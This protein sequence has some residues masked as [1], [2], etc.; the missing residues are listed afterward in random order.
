[1]IE[2]KLQKRFVKQLI[3][4]VMQL[5]L[6]IENKSPNTKCLIIECFIS[7]LYFYPFKI[8]W[9]HKQH[10]SS[11]TS[12]SE[13]FCFDSNIPIYFSMQKYLGMNVKFFDECSRFLLIDKWFFSLITQIFTFFFPFKFFGKLSV[14]QTWLL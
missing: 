13:I 7:M 1:M 14:Q 8:K 12:F 3:L 9:K 5:K 11:T 4:Y 10:F 6:T 2:L